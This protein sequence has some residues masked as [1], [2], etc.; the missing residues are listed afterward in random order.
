M[1]GADKKQQDEE[2]EEEQQV[3]EDE[4]EAWQAG[5][6]AD[7]QAGSILFGSRST[8]FFLIAS[9]AD[10]LMQFPHGRMRQKQ[11]TDRCWLPMGGWTGFGQ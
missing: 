5:R 7:R 6:K 9:I 10:S 11:A 4:H 2:E 3:E 1:R 8:H